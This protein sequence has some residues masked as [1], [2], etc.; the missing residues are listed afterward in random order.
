MKAYICKVCGYLYDEESAEKNV[1]NQPTPFEE[2]DTDWI[3][4]GCGV[5]QTL[6]EETYSSRPPDVPAK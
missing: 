3:C 5:S 4:P 1:E 6:F 2:L